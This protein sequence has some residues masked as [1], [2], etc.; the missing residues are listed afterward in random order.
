MRTMSN[1]VETAPI[2]AAVIDGTLLN[3]AHLIP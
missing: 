3:I 1:S 2:A